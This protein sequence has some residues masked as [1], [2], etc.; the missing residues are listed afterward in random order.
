MEWLL[1]AVLVVAAVW[2][3]SAPLRRAASGEA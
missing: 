3:V 2:V 1:V